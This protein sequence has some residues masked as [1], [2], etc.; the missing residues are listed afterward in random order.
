MALYTLCHVLSVQALSLPELLDE[1]AVQGEHGSG[2]LQDF[3]P[4]LSLQ[5]VDGSHL[6]RQAV[7]L[8][9]QIILSLPLHLL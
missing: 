7:R 6:N 8:R 2:G 5:V 3:G 1:Q 9:A 4:P